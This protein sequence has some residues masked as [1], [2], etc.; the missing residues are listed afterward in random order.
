MI[1][2]NPTTG[3]Q[4]VVSP[5]PGGNFADNFFGTPQGI[6][7]AGNGD[8][9]V[10]DRGCC[11][12]HG[13]VIRV[14]PVDGRQTVVA[15]SPPGSPFAS[16]QGIAIGIAQ[17]VLVADPECCIFDGGVIRVN[18]AK[19]A[20]DNQT[21]VS[22]RPGQISMFDGPIGIAVV[23]AIVPPG[24]PPVGVCGGSVPCSCGDRVVRDRTLA[25]GRSGDPDRLPGRRPGRRAPG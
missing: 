9:F 7:I 16:P 23:S 13:G 10:V 19:P 22:P 17:D 12:P 3:H 20:D 6:A 2:V 11:G 18:P 8:L 15:S 21:V 14:N 24:P 25:R 1:R 5:P 4:T